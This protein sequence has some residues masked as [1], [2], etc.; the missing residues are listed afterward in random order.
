[1]GAT[2]IDDHIRKGSHNSLLQYCLCYNIGG[3]NVAPNI[4][5]KRTKRAKDGV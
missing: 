2:L 4:E 5:L 3:G 1:M